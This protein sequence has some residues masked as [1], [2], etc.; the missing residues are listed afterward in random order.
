MIELQ[1]KDCREWKPR[2]FFSPDASCRSGY[3]SQCRKCRTA[4]VRAHQRKM[5][6]RPLAE[7]TSGAA[8]DEFA[9]EL[10]STMQTYWHV[11]MNNNLVGWTL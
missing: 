1:C 9:R 5:E 10:F 6:K 11:G 8:R 2:A 7:R 3:R 4:Q